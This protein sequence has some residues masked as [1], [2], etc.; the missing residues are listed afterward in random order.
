V[1][2]STALQCLCSIR[3]RWE[4]AN[5]PRA[6]ESWSEH[7]RALDLCGICTLFRSFFSKDSDADESSILLLVCYQTLSSLVLLAEIFS[8]L[9]VCCICGSSRR[10][11][12]YK[13]MATEL[14]VCFYMNSVHNEHN[15]HPAMDNQRLK[16]FSNTNFPFI[17]CCSFPALSQTSY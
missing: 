7:F 3:Y 16:H 10:R 4:R 9:L 17:F 13:H 12:L 11:V 1:H 6:F 5:V 14:A 8:Q 15:T 2:Y